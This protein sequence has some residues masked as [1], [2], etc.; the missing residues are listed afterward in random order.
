MPPHGVSL[1]R[2]S[3]ICEGVASTSAAEAKQPLVLTFAKRHVEGRDR[4]S[5]LRLVRIYE[6]WTL[7]THGVAETRGFERASGRDTVL[8]LRGK[9]QFDGPAPPAELR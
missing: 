1:P 8:V 4:G 5:E 6:G 2:E 9:R 3:R 7:M